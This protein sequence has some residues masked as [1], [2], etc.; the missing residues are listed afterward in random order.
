MAD[1]ML[2]SFRVEYN[3]IANGGLRVELDFVS[4]STTLQQAAVQFLASSHF[5]AGAQLVSIAFTGRLA[6]VRGGTAP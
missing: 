3:D 2:N 1:V 5:P 4:D 6:V